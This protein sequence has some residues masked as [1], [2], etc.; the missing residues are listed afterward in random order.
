V[1]V[2]L[3]EIRDR[4][5]FIPA[6]AVALTVENADIR[7]EQDIAREN[8]EVY[9]LRRAG[10]SRERIWEGTSQPYILLTRLNGDGSPAHYDAY[11][12]EN[13][14]WNAVR[15]WLDA[16]WSHVKSGDVVDVEYIL[17]L[18][19]EPKASERLTTSL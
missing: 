9:L 13:R 6:I 2:K 18:T 16:N 3:I 12:W 14:T 11:S 8:A 7:N 15:Q 19:D 1:E 4:A 5:T 17:G 10:Y